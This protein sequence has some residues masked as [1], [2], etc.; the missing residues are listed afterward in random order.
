MHSCGT[1]SRACIDCSSFVILSL[2]ASNLRFGIPGT[3][4]SVEAS[5]RQYRWKTMLRSWR[6]NEVISSRVSG[7]RAT[8]VVETAVDVKA[9]EVRVA[10]DD[11]KNS[12]SPIVSSA[13]L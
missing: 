4:A 11:E 12:S 6:E 2:A 3:V 8:T 10:G 1:Y 7:L 13:W 9:A 5:S